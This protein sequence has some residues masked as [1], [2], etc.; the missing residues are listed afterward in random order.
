MTHG[1]VLAELAR[2]GPF[3]A[4]E[5]HPAGSAPQAGWRPLEELLRQ[6][7]ALE[8]R[9]AA[10]RAALAQAGGLQPGD[11]EPRVAVSLT[12]LGLAAR[13]ICPALGV[14]VLTGRLLPVEPG[15]LRWRPGTGA[16]GLSLRADA[17][18]PAG[19][20]ATSLATLADALAD[21]VL[22]GPVRELIEGSTKLGVSPQVLWGNVASALNGTRALID[23]AEPAL[24]GRTEELVSRLLSR[25]PLQDTHQGSAA[26]GF[27]RRSC[28]LVYRLSPTQAPVCGDCVLVV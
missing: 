24:L 16:I 20:A 10:V 9:V 27:R 7:G 12:Q 13:L 22:G 26:T 5:A 2:L 14:A 19:S 28:C 6:P 17:V 4:L 18:P 3:F 25:P 15:L 1:A 11:V 8:A 23:A 21:T